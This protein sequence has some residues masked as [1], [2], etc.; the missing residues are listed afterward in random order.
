MNPSNSQSNASLLE[1]PRPVLRGLR[2][3]GQEL[4]VARRLRRWTQQ[5]LAER[6]GTS[7]NS[8]R[9]MEEGSPGIALHTF[10][11][12]LHVLGRLDDVVQSMALKKDEWGIDLALEQLP[13]R[14]HAPA[15]PADQA[16]VVARPRSM[17][18][19]SGQA[20]KPPKVRPNMQEHPSRITDEIEG[21]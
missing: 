8:V 12:A 4:S 2:K 5:E 18:D 1:L 13:L 16:E 11:G 9:R 19:A 20:R 10:L 3:L 15:K 17:E 14:V 6:I 7:I 21:F